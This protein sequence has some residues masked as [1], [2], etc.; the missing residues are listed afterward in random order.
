[1]HENYWL[2]VIRWHHSH[3]S[4]G[5]LKDLSSLIQTAKR[6]VL[7]DALVRDDSDMER[8]DEGEARNDKK[9]G[10]GRVRPCDEISPPLP[11]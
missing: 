9:K 10:V 4:N 2:G 6:R 5:L 8:R 3:V 7:G 1:M 11:V